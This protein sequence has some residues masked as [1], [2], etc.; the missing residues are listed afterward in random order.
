MVLSLMGVQ[1]L[2]AASGPLFPGQQFD[3]GDCPTSVAIADLDGDGDADLAVANEGSYPSYDG[4]V[5]VLLN[6]GDGTF[7]ADVTFGAKEAVRITAA[8]V[9]HSR[10]T[11][12]TRY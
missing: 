12:E 11:Y 5:S 9:Q 6:H 10:E 1:G 3:A 4:S 7:A 2:R 8:S